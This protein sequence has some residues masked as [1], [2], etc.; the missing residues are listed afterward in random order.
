MLN[1]LK[2]RRKTEAPPEE[3]LSPGE[4]RR[5]QELMD[6][7]LDT[8]LELSAE[9]HKIA[10]TEGRDGMRIGGIM[11]TVCGAIGYVLHH[12]HLEDK[13]FCPLM[14]TATVI[15]AVWLVFG[16]VDYLFARNGQ[17]NTEENIPS[18]K[19]LELDYKNYDLMKSHPEVF[20][21]VATSDYVDTRIEWDKR[22]KKTG[23]NRFAPA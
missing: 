12:E 17:Y 13:I 11:A 4:A 3:I 19:A 23:A 18:D 10:L 2:R 15:G 22:H 8:R 21:G 9:Q 14:D 1:L 16:T 5:R 20:D 6:E 7:Y